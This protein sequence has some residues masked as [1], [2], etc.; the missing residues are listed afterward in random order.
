MHDLDQLQ[1]DFDEATRTVLAPL[2]GRFGFTLHMVKPVLARF[3]SGLVTV[4]LGFGLY[5]YG[6][7]LSAKRTD[8]PNQEIT[9]TAIV[10][11]GGG[12]E[13][14]GFQA[15]TSERVFECVTLITGLLE[16]YGTKLLLGDGDA[17]DGMVAISRAQSERYT[18]ALAALGIGPVRRAAEAAW[19]AKRYKEVVK[20]YEAMMAHLSDGERRRLEYAKKRLRRRWGLGWLKWF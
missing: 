4:D 18:A 19:L 1:L 14:T 3:Q 16:K 5:D 13:P 12:T 17:F 20:Q 9:L 8:R 10:E 7:D 2:L 15:S 6:L 11:A